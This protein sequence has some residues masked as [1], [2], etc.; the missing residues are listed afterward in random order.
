MAAAEYRDIADALRA[1]GWC[2]RADFL[3]PELT[4][5]LRAE[6]IERRT[7]LVPAAIGRGRAQQ[8]APAVRADATLWLD[9]SS[10]VQRRLLEQ[11]ETLRLELNRHLLLGLFDLEAHYACYAP[12]AGYARHLDTFHAEEERVTAPRRILSLVLYLN[13]NWQ[14]ADGGELLLWDGERELAR[15]YPEGGSAVFFLSAEFPH[16]VL[17]PRAERYSVAGW[18]RDNAG[19]ARV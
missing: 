11:L 17:P 7:A 5:E 6:L 13:E 15:C 9:G 16:T 8:L 14:A 19:A 1:E 4:A 10:P 3:P 12:G 2:R 18:F